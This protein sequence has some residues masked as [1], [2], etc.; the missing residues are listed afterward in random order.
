MSSRVRVA[1]ANERE[2]NRFMPPLSCGGADG[3][4]KKAVEQRSVAKFTANHGLKRKEWR[5]SNPAQSKRWG[6]ICFGFAKHE[7][8]LVPFNPLPTFICH[9]HRLVWAVS[10]LNLVKRD[11]IFLLESA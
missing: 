11:E 8:V 2:G 4:R 1:V 6:F 3:A 7:L 9:F 5:D 10:V